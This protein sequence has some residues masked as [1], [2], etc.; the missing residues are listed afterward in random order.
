MGEDLFQVKRTTRAY[1]ANNR[2]IFLQIS[3]NL[4]NLES[5]FYRCHAEIA[6]KIIMS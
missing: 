3:F 4:I 1:K 2:L 6:N 5:K